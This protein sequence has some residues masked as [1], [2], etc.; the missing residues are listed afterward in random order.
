VAA[1]DQ[2]PIKPCC[3]RGCGQVTFAHLG[4]AKVWALAVTVAF[5]VLPAQLQ[6]HCHS[7]IL[8][9]ELLCLTS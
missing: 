8:V 9:L 7:N 4:E 2:D 1:A 5:G 3:F 6:L